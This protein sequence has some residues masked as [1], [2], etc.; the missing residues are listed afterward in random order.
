MLTRVKV[1]RCDIVTLYLSWLVRTRQDLQ[2][3]LY[4][5]SHA[6]SQKWD[7]LGLYFRS[8]EPWLSTT[9]I[10]S[11]LEE[12]FISLNLCSRGGHPYDIVAIKI[13]LCPWN[14]SFLPPRGSKTWLAHLHSFGLPACFSCPRKIW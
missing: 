4:G 2:P 7:P 6:A 8:A 1:I 5:L 14:A 11:P 12:Q 13:H 10:L 9:V 3:Y